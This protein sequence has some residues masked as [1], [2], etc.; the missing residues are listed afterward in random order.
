[1]FI[2]F[3]VYILECADLTYYIGYTIDLEKRIKL[4]NEGKASKYTRARLPV[5]AIYYEA[6]E[7]KSNALKREIAL[8][9]LTRQQ[10]LQLLNEQKE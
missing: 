8:K 4:H 1:M 3:Y 9:R 5:R 2:V 7:T 10:K 6:H